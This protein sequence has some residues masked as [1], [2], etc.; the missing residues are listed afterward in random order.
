MVGQD[1]DSPGDPVVVA[2]ERVLDAERDGMA[3]L[4]RC[5]DEAQTLVAQS[6]AIA[7]VIGQR[8]DSRISKL[9]AAY[10][11]RLEQDIDQLGRP[12]RATADTV[13]KRFERAN[14]ERAVAR[15][16]ARLSGES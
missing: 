14:L 11:Q 2:I 5:R 8:A 9:H 6:R 4:E 12:D 15:V 7:A 10:L 1:D 16:A 13:D 3:R